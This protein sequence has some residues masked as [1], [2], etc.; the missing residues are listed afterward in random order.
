M[1]VSDNVLPPYEPLTVKG[2]SVFC[3]GRE[4]HFADNGLPDKI[5]TAG[6]RF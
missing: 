1:G 2:N 5:V 3:W 6:K 4:Y